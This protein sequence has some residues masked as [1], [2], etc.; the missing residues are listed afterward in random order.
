[1]PSKNDDQKS[2]ATRGS[3]DHSKRASKSP[4][5]DTTFGPC[6]VVSAGPCMEPP[7]ELPRGAKKPQR[8]PE[9]DPRLLQD[10]PKRLQDRPKHGL[11]MVQQWFN[12]FNNGLT[13]ST[14]V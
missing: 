11:N 12:W 13:V 10:H 9:E 6:K 14:M 2:T 3:Q 4:P 8:D 5:T 7:K 1:M